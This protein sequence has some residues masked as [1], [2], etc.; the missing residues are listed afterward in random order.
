VQDAQGRL[1]EA[2]AVYR[3]QVLT[4]FKEVEDQLAALRLLHEQAEAQGRAV[5]AAR[6]ATTLSDRC[7]PGCDER[8]RAS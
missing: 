4:A 7:S 6:R 3:G 8:G 5:T 2:L 1:D